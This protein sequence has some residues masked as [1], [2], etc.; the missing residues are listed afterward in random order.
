ML[1]YFFFRWIIFNNA[2]VIVSYVY[3]FYIFLDILVLAG[4]KTFLFYAS[5]FCEIKKFYTIVNKKSY[6]VVKVYRLLTIG[7]DIN[8][9]KNKNNISDELLKIK[10]HSVF[11]SCR[12]RDKLKIDVDYYFHVLYYGLRIIIIMIVIFVVIK[13]IIITI[14]FIITNLLWHLVIIGVNLNNISKFYWNRISRTWDID[15]KKFCIDFEH[16]C[17]VKKL[18]IALK[19]IW[20]DF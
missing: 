8:N 10:L 6:C 5:Y 20:F 11:D 3:F 14:V 16:Q 18:F 2:N 19:L 13:I 1:T 9:S 15:L 12:W 7:L 17:N 4:K